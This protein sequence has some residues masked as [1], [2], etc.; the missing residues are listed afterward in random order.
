MAGRAS[1]RFM[2]G[3]VRSPSGRVSHTKVWTNVAFAL[4]TVVVAWYAFQMLLSTEMFA[5]YMLTV[6]GR[7][8]GSKYLALNN[9][10]APEVG[11]LNE[12]ELKNDCV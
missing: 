3:L 1:Q 6:A 8:L 2:A 4:A 12:G 5:S 9:A 11:A 10:T 7:G